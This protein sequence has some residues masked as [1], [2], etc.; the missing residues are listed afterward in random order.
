MTL[1]QLVLRAAERTPEAVAVRG[2]DALL[3]YGALDGAANRVARAL[4]ELGVGPGDRVGL[5]LEKS[6]TAVIA[7]QAVL[8]L[9]AA[10]VPL[11]PLSPVARA[12]TIARNCEM[13]AVV[14]GSGRADALAAQVPGMALLRCEE[15]EGLPFAAQAAYS[16]APLEPVI[17]REDDLAYILYTSG[18]TGT[19]K[20]VCL[21]HRN[22]LAFVEWAATELAAGPGDRFSNHAPFHFDLSVLDLYVAFWAGAS[23]SIV[24][25]ALAYS[26]QRLTE[27]LSEQEITVWYSVPSALMLMMDHGGLLQTQTPA[28]R[29]VLFAGEPFPLKHLRRLRRH[30][31]APRFLN[32]YGPTETNVCTFYEVVGQLPEERTEP[33]PIGVACCGDR[34][35]VADRGPKSEEDSTEVGLLMV[36]G[37]TV[38]LGYWG[39]PPH[40]GPYSTGDLVSVDREGNYVYHG[41]RD[42]MVKVRGRRIEL[43]EIEAVLL[44][45]PN[46]AEACVIVHGTGMEAKLIAFL[47]PGSADQRLGLLEMKRHCAAHLPPYMIVDSVRTLTQL[48]RTRN[49]KTDRLALARLLQG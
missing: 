32:L 23:V 41:R 25:E 38:M 11:D 14:T 27:F 30:L 2:P 22:A 10:Y 5:W 16:A 24:P 35:F 19:P 47:V 34:T 33:V 31:P 49:G 28:L 36:E 4:R 12:A 15:R 37:P 1:E 40:Q 39:Q 7:M 26:P 3:T 43:G 18:S 17:R 48:P 21:S 8:R 42:N 20:G 44:S 46:V 9:G 45:N 29:A 6:G 13:R